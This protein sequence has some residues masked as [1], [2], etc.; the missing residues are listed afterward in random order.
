MSEKPTQALVSVLIP[1]YRVEKYVARCLYSV[2]NQTYRPLELVIVDDRGGDRSMEIV[3]ELLPE[4]SSEL[5][6]RL[7]Q[8][9]TNRGVA[10]CRQKLLEEASGDYCLYLDSD[11]YWHSPDSLECLMQ[12]MLSTGVDC[13]VTDYYADYPKKKE[14]MRV[15]CPISSTDAAKAVLSGQMPG[16]MWNKCFHTEALRHHGGGFAPG[17]RLMEDLRAIIPFFASNI[18]IA[19]LPMAL[20]HYEQGNV[21]SLLSTTGAKDLNE[22]MEAVDYCRD[23]L[24]RRDPQAQERYGR[25]IQMAYLNAKA[26]LYARSPLSFY[27]HIRACH[28]EVDHLNK[29]RPAAWYHKLIYKLQSQALTGSLGYV[30]L[31]LLNRWKSFLRR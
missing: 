18:R 13:L 22:L 25:E 10:Y 8:N 9:E 4:S 24:L 21:S 6:I 17:K 5:Q 1:V 3:R 15:N 27:P 11:D 31:L 14:Y 23:E 16:F 26:L 30:L 2:L 19:Y 28:P 20:V 29:I 7:L 12:A